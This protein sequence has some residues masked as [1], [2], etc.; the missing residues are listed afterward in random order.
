[1]YVAIA[2]SSLSVA[3]A[4]T[5][6]P[7]APPVAP[8]A[9][10]AAPQTPAP[11]GQVAQLPS[12][13]V[14]GVDD[15][16]GVLFWR[17]TTM[18][19]DVVVRPDG[20][21]SLPLLNDVPAAGLTPDQL[22][23]QVLELAKKFV[24]DPSVAVVVRQVNSRKVFITGRVTRPGNYPLN[25]AMTVL[26]LLAQAGGLTEF[27]NGKEITIIRQ[28]EPRPLRF[29]YDEVSKGR[30]LEQNVLLKV[31]DTIVVP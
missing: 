22:R 14:I 2:L 29:N 19:A 23:E 3:H 12:D 11:T 10:T 4:Q 28:G 7:V 5:A 6:P 31:G 1:V 8:P 17:D 13:Y 27:A 30:K 21:I 20:K 9:G 25:S 24:T 18:T 26:Q 16:L 15:Q